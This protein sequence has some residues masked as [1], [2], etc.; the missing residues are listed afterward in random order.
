MRATDPRRADDG[1]GKGRSFS[2][3]T[4]AAPAPRPA[5][6]RMA[7][8]AWDGDGNGVRPSDDHMRPSTCRPAC[9]SPRRETILVTEFSFL[10]MSFA[11][12][13]P[14]DIDAAS[15]SL[16]R[17]TSIAGAPLRHSVR[18]LVR[19]IQ[20]DSTNIESDI[21]MQPESSEATSE[22]P[23]DNDETQ[24]T[25]VAPEA[26]EGERPAT[27]ERELHITS[28]VRN[29][30]LNLRRECERHSL[31]PTTVDSMAPSHGARRRGYSNPIEY[32]GSPLRIRHRPSP[33]TPPVLETPKAEFLPRLV[34]NV[35]H[36]LRRLSLLKSTRPS[37][38]ETEAVDGARWKIVELAFRFGGPHRYYLVQAVNMFY[39][40]QKFGRRGNPHPT[41]LLCHQY[42]TLQWEHKRGGYSAPVDLATV[43]VLLDG[44]STAVFQKHKRVS[45]RNEA[46]SLSIVFGGR[47]LDLETSSQDHRDWLSSALRTLVSYA[48]KQRRAEEVVVLDEEK[49]HRAPVMA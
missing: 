29:L 43:D 13:F 28:S 4:D 46:C 18:K 34:S 40:L 24:P 3:L 36:S 35:A 14:L 20:H 21:A 17:T 15:P 6:P 39:P 49:R 44:R 33:G 27:P 48:K 8:L 5:T 47:T 19:E 25:A 22:R 37:P 30:V 41:R 38:G 11:P 31:Q 7:Y 23:T 26:Q 42:G 2:L 16:T 32:R 1:L 10:H 45:K 9:T 12:P